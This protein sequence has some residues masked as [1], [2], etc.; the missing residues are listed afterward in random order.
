MPCL[1]PERRRGDLWRILGRRSRCLDRAGRTKTV[2]SQSALDRA[3]AHSELH[4]VR[5]SAANAG[6]DA[7]RVSGSH[8]S[9]HTSGK[10]V[11]PGPLTE[12]GPHCYCLRNPLASP[13]EAPQ[14]NWP[15]HSALIQPL[16][17]PLLVSRLHHFQP[18]AL[19]AAWRTPTLKTCKRWFLTHKLHLAWA[20][21][22]FV[23]LL[24]FL[25]LTACFSL[26]DCV[27]F[28]AWLR[29]FFRCRLF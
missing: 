8:G 15:T 28:F 3:Y 7:G 14:Q 21:L 2:V 1:D 13:Q 25:S 29:A 19:D 4:Q 23:P 9:F 18:P 24:L 27:F 10:V 22:R 6:L 16:C 20:L 5:R 26:P 12:K 11:P 17:S